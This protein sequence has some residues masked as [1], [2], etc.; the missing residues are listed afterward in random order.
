MDKRGYVYIMTN[1]PDGVMYTGVTSNLV[2]RV[3]E[4]RNSLVDGFTSKYNCKRLIY[5]EEHPTM[6]GAIS[7]EKAM[8]KW[9]RSLKLRLINATNP[10]WCDLWRAITSS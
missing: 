7:R 4:H 5:F 2:K 1:K 9:N 6:S 8:K 10:D 3:Y